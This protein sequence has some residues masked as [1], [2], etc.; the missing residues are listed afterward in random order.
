MTN[1]PLFFHLLI[2]VILFVAVFSNFTVYASEI[3]L[4]RSKLVQLALHLEVADKQ[5]Q[6]DFARIALI[7]MYNT[8]QYELERS[9]SHLPQTLK[10][11]AKVRSWRFATQS[12]LETINNLSFFISKQ[13]K[14][15]LL[16]GISV[17]L[18]TQPRN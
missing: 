10:K 11:R 9:L 6:Y 7:E 18:L 13:N 1:K 2:V 16:I 3:N 8:Y 12:Y 15:F 4:S 17:P 5:K 14:I